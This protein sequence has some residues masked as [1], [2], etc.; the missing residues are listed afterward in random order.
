MG[1]YSKKLIALA[2]SAVVGIGLVACDSN[3]ESEQVQEEEETTQERTFRELTDEDLE[4]LPFFATGPIATV[5]G[6]EVTAE[7]FNDAVFEQVERLPFPIQPSMV[8]EF[9]SQAVDAVINQ[10]L[11]DRRLAEENI[12]VTDEDVDA[13][14]EQFKAGMGGD[15]EMYKMQLEMMGI[16]EDDFREQLVEHARLEKFLEQEYDLGIDEEELRQMFEQF[17]HQFEQGDQVHARHILVKVDQDADDEAVAE[18]EARA[19]SIAEQA[20]ADDAD[21]EE[22]ARE[23]SEGP[24]ADRGGDLGFFSR[25]D[26]VPA[27]S[28]AAFS[29]EA[30]DV[31]EPVRSPFGF[32]VI[33]VVDTKEGQEADFDEVRPQLELRAKEQQFREH[34]Q[35]FI[36]ELRDGIEIE[37]LAD[38]I[39]LNVDPQAAP[40]GMPPMPHG[41][42]QGQQLQLQQGAGEGGEVQIDPEQLEALQRELQLQLE[43]GHEGHNH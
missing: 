41:A 16:D 33:Q 26:M 43:Q 37:E 17:K 31:S 36:D 14:I 2:M 1:S 38:N 19:A 40:Q 15:D 20:Q 32:H 18:A 23:Y 9:R 42:G 5:D 4:S 7:R 3:G 8:E 22:L 12:E 29:M 39:E 27:F 24:T 28:D 34:F 11:I 21:F 10:F 30:G 35:K 6:D 13:L 25:Q